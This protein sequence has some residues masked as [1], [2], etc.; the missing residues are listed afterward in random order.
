MADTTFRTK[1]KPLPR[2]IFA[3]VSLAPVE[4]VALLADDEATAAAHAM[5]PS[6]KKYLVYISLLAGINFRKDIRDIRARYEFC[7]IG[8]GFPADDYLVDASMSVPVFPSIEHPNSVA[9]IRPSQR[10]PWNNLYLHTLRNFT[11]EPT[12]THP[13]HGPYISISVEDRDASELRCVCDSQRPADEFQAA[14]AAQR[15]RGPKQ[16]DADDG[17]CDSLTSP[18]DD[19]D[20][21]F[22]LQ[23]YLQPRVEMWL[24]PF[25]ASNIGQP[26]EFAEEFTRLQQIEKEWYARVC[27]T[28]MRQVTV[29]WLAKLEADPVHPDTPPD[30]PGDAEGEQPMVE[31]GPDDACS[32]D[33][34]DVSEL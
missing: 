29:D 23:R 27:R 28:R 9:P 22:K 11:A 21:A 7:L 8:I 16:E 2:G 26:E 32:T 19:S 30:P 13:S 33:E 4:S 15:S 34:N 6:C 25:D 18:S 5:V 3:A 1:R 20:S 31:L 10:L 17:D 12:I 14:Q 24:D